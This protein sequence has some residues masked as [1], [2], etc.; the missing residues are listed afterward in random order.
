LVESNTTALEQDLRQQ[1]IADAGS[2]QLSGFEDL[3]AVWNRAYLL[4]GLKPALATPRD[5]TFVTA[6]AAIG[7]IT[8]RFVL[9]NKDGNAPL[10]V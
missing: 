9:E 3:S 4:S 1:E 10:Q 8:G 2:Y 6:G 7:D 5:R